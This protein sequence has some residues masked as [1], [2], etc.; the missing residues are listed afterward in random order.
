[1]S[2]W[3]DKKKPII[4]LSPMDGV[5][6]EPMRHITA[7]YGHPGVIFTEFINVEYAAHRPDKILERFF[8][9]SIERPT[10]AQ[11]SGSTPSLFYQFAFVAAYLGFDGIDINMGCPSRT[12]THRG[13]G[14]ALIGN[15][16]LAQELVLSAR[17]GFEDWQTGKKI[18]NVV[19]DRS[20]LTAVEAINKRNRSLGISRGPRRV[21][22][23]VKT[24]LGIRKAC[25]NS[26]L[27]FLASLPLEAI[28]VH[29]RTLEAGHSGP[30]DWGAIALAA[31]IAHREGKILLGNGGIKSW[32]EAKRVSSD[33]GLD[34][35][36]IGRGAMG[37]PW[38]FTDKV[39]ER[40]E[41]L[42]VMV[43]HIRYYLNLSGNED[44][45]S[46]RKHLSWY[47]KGFPGA[48]RLRG[49]LIRTSSLAEVEE[50]VVGNHTVV[51][52]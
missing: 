12:V 16:E 34:G 21:G 27:G 5:T 32:A 51:D 31:K 22:L 33:Y 36:L 26:W 1:M 37:N 29:G 4:G 6:D 42:S 18:T 10:V 3:Q 8:Y 11:I 17:R 43:E 52:N 19:A 25:V 46:L 24:R 44:F 2:F 40:Q 28:T 30:V 49:R 39:P 7:K 47:A 48:K 45:I 38:A 20:V 13:G 23:S 50:I 9:S 14:A 35:V 15:R 41:R